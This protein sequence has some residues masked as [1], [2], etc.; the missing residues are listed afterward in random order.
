[1]LVSAIQH[2]LDQDSDDD[3]PQEDSDEGGDD[4]GDDRPELTRALLTDLYHE[5]GLS[6][7]EI[8]AETGYSKGW[9]SQ[10]MAQLGVETYT[11]RS[12]YHDL[13]EELLAYLDWL[14]PK[15]QA[16]IRAVALDGKQ[17]VEQAAERGVE[18]S[19]VRANLRH[20]VRRLREI[21]HE[22]GDE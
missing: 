3:E 1:M 4:A 8:A 7:P 14:T 5:Q 19:S 17:I 11:T 18:P 16:D 10:T 22:Q 6:V 20:G 13:D 12:Q 15:Q 9:I 21:A 2:S